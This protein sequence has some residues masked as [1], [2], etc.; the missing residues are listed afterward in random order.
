[1][2]DYSYAKPIFLTD[3][4]KNL[5]DK[6]YLILNNLVATFTDAQI[7]PKGNAITPINVCKS[8]RQ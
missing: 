4:A 7:N 3:T 5:N 2:A 1:M 6:F 8:C